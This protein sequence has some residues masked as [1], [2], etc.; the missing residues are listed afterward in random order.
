MPAAV[1]SFWYPFRLCHYSAPARGGKSKFLKST[2]KVS[3]P[4]SSEEIRAIADRLYDGREQHGSVRR[5]LE[6]LEEAA[7]DYGALWRLSRAHFF[8][9]QE[10]RDL[11]EARSHHLAGVDAGRRAARNSPE[12]VEGHFWLGVNLALLA[13]LEKPTGAL[14]A[15]LG[16][17]RELK[18]AAK[19]DRAYHAAGP[20]RV[21]ARLESKLPRILGGGK[22]RARAHFEEAIRLAPSNTVTRIYFAELLLEGG[23]TERA[24]AELEALLAIPFDPAW[25]FEIRRDRKKAEEMLLGDGGLGVGG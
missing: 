25:A 7:D 17:R 19:I 5:S 1:R 20:L 13:R 23:D 9:G 21:L 8:L 4:E 14:R 11:E 22:N 15:A 24:R 2:G 3:M 6:L 18:R 12:L 10:A 16:A